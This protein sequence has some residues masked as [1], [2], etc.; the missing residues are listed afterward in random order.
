[1]AAYYTN[2]DAIANRLR[3]RLEFQDNNPLYS[4]AAAQIVNPTLIN[5]VIVQVEAR[6]NAA[7]G[8]IYCLPIPLNKTSAIAIVSSIVEKFVVAEIISVHYQQAQNPEVGGDAGYGGKILNEA[9]QELTALL[10]GHGIHI[11]GMTIQPSS[12]MQGITQPIMLPGVKLKTEEQQ[13]D[14]ITRN[15]TFSGIMEDPDHEPIKWD[16]G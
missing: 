9:K 2:N 14:S 1:M 4:G 7:L 10:H 15:Y 12:S 6:V 8:Q 5:Q 3:G 11:A 13:P 16:Y